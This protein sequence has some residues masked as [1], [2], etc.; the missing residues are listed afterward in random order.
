VISILDFGENIGTYDYTVSRPVVPNLFWCIPPFT[1][2]A[3][4]YSSP[5]E[6]SFLSCLGS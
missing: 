2:F 5:M 4:F 6:H 1:H 3:T